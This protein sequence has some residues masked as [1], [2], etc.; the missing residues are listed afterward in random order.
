MGEGGKGERGQHLS[1][2]ENKPHRLKRHL[3][4]AKRP[5]EGGRMGEGGVGCGGRGTT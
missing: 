2:P 4:W 3:I 5:S 1:S